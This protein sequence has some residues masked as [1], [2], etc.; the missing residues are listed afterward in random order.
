MG[1]YSQV[2]FAMS[3]N[4]YNQMRQITPTYRGESL[5]EA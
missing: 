4:K 1:Y 5:K 2:G 3:E